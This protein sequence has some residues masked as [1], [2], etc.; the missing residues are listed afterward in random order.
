[1]RKEPRSFHLACALTAL[2]LLSAATVIAEQARAPEGLSASDWSSIRVAYEAN[3]HAACAVEGGYQARNPGQQWR[4]HFDGRGFIVTPDAD[5]W[6]WGLELVGYGRA[7]SQGA[8]AS[9]RCEKTTPVIEQ[10]EQ[11]IEYNWDET[12]TEWYVNDPRGL[13][14][15][16]TVHQRPEEAGVARASRPSLLQFTLPLVRESL[17]ARTVVG[18]LSD[19]AIRRATSAFSGMDSWK[20]GCEKGF[21]HQQLTG[22]MPVPHHSVRPHLQFTLAVRGNLRPRISPDGR[23]V[24]FVNDAGAAVVNYN[25]LTVFDA[26][27]ATIPAWFEI[28]DSNPQGVYPPRRAIPNSQSEIRNPKSLR[29]VVDDSDAVYPLTIDPV[30]QQAYLKA[31]NTDVD[32]FF[33]YSV[34]VSGDTVVVGAYSEDS[35]ATGVNGNQTD[36]S[37]GNSGA[38]YVFVRAGGVWSQQAYLKASNTGADDNFGVSVAVSGDTVVVGADSE[39][40]SATGVNGYQDDN[41]AFWAGAAYVF[42]RDGNGMW[43]QQAY[44]KASNTGADDNFGVSVAVSGDTV[45]VGAYGEASNATGV[46]GDQADNSAIA[47]GAAY[48]FVRAGG[49]WSHLAYLKASNTGAVDLFGRS[50][51]VSGDTVVVGAI[52]EASSATGVNGNQADNSATNAGA[53]YVFT[54][55]GPPDADGDGVPDENDACPN[56]APGLPVDCAGRPLRDCNGDC[57]VDGADVQCLVD[58]LLRL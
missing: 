54:G 47:A 28:G 11:R 22:R 6:S 9:R 50:V 7:N 5:G 25:G 36:N 10:C 19:E 29:L 41:S 2:T 58:E 52:G 57:L 30:A 16:Y 8:S 27:G 46:N 26:T 12:L 48:V 53:A 40:S 55:V 1:M 42:V 38:V 18:I 15:G 56:N 51:S 43:S 37:A 39:D 34:G 3:R 31:S 14:H 17:L 23:N 44:L 32:D 35:S 49:V 20:R 33:G 24:A 45:V 13:E 4:T 21:S